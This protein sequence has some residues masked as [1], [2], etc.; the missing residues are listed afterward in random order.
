MPGLATVQSL[1]E[2]H[3][4]VCA[5]VVQRRP[6]AAVY[7]GAWRRFCPG[8][9]GFGVAGQY[10]AVCY[11]CGGEKAAV[12]CGRTLEWELGAVSHWKNSGASSGWTGLGK[13][14]PTLASVA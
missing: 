12:H 6:I 3:R 13:Q 1:E 2:I 11:Q 4:L 7:D 5:A 14:N 8:A 10:R 9:L